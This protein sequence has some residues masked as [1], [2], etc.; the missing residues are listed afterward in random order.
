M[1]GKGAKVQKWTLKKVEIVKQSEPLFQNCRMKK[2][3]RH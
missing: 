1:P 2:Q 3:N